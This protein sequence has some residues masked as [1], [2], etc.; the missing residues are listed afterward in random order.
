[1]LRFEV[2]GPRHGAGNAPVIVLLHG[3]GADEKDLVE[4]RALLPGNAVLVTP[5]A[6]FPGEPWGYGGGYAWYD[7][8]ERDRPEPESFEESQRELRRFLERLPELLELRPSPL[9]LGGFSQGGTMSL[10]Y[11][12]RHPGAVPIVVNLSGF[13]PDHPTVSVKPDAVAA[14][15][16][17]WGHGVHDP[18]IPFELAQQGRIALA[19]AGADLEARDFPIGHWIDRAEMDALV[20]WLAPQLEVGGHRR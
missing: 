13:L 2:H 16:F 1:M 11:A 8:L 15:R 3:R 12:L 7:Y 17:F 10:G 6:P 4:L 9:V 20:E 18:A 19:S 14:T 5:R